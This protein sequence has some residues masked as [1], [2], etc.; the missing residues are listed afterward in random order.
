MVFGRLRRRPRSRKSQVNRSSGAGVKAVSC[1]IP[2]ITAVGSSSYATPSITL[3]LLIDLMGSKYLEKLDGTAK[4]RKVATPRVLAPPVY[5]VGYLRR[6]DHVGGPAI[7]GCDDLVA[8]S[9]PITARP[10]LSLGSSAPT[11]R[12]RRQKKPTQQAP[13]RKVYGRFA[14]AE[15]DVSHM[16]S[17]GPT[18]AGRGVGREQEERR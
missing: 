1:S 11:L 2:F 13:R 18:G 10:R 4:L 16:S 7:R 9:D 12:R 14:P 17:S 15:A 6:V 8:R 3:S 5:P